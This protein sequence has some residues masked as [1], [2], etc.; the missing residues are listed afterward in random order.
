MSRYFMLRDHMSYPGRWV[1]RSPVDEQGEEIEPWQFKKGR[2]V[3]VAGVPY[4]P[5]SHRGCA[6][7]ISQTGLGVPVI[8]GRVADILER[9]CAQDV[10]LLPARVEGQTDSWFILNLLRVIR[11][12]DE[13]RCEYV[14]YWKPEDNR[15][16]K[17]GEYHNVRGLKVDPTKIG[18]AHIF[19]PWGWRVAIVV[20]E[21]LKLAL[22]EA[23]I[24][25]M[26][27]VEA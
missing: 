11:C 17:V 1:L 12:I 7:D 6:L 8:H 20:S 9:L 27:Y 18:D 16:E 25:G 4:L 19:R 2:R 13:A 26:K 14:D 10:Q 3:E 21:P 23:G 15:P 5:M 24:T 22:E